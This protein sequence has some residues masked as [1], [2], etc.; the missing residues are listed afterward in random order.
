MAAW[1]SRYFRRH[2]NALR[3]AAWG[4][5]IP[6]TGPLVVYSNHPS[7]WDAAV[8]ILLADRLFP[9]CEGYAPIDAAM[10]G[11]YG[12][13]AR[14][15]AFAVDLDSPRGAASFLRA[16]A[17]VLSRPDRVLWIAAQGRFADPRQRPVD[18]RGGLG[19]LAELAP[20]TRFMPLA[21]EYAFWTERGAEALAA[22]G[23]PMTGRELL[24]LP[25]PTRLAHL[26]AA[27][28]ATMD[29]LAADAIARDP[30]RFVPV[31]EGK[32]GIGGVYDGWRRLR[33]MIHGRP[34]NP[35]HG[36]PGA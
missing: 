1:F 13:F 9:T 29:R 17:D 15:G 20:D 7:W 10:L 35:A 28:A 11:K 23:A 4:M 36:S 31:L 26:E 2:M 6:G 19:R 5:P 32:A 34:F 25:R 8:Y 14:I 16:S 24:A 30:A 3:V 33:A 27:L 21:V 18:L 12:F 22:F